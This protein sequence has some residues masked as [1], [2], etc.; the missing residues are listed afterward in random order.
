VQSASFALFT[1]NTGGWTDEV[2]FQGIPRTVENGQQVFFNNVGNGFFS[3]MGIPLVAGR[4]FNVHDTQTSPKVAVINETM[5]RRFFPNRSPIG[6]RFGIGD[7]PDHPGEIE[8]VG[9]VKDAKYTALDEGAQMAAYLPCEQ[10]TG[11]Y[12]N[13]GVRYAA[14]T[15]T[16]LLISE[17]RSAIAQANPNILVNSVSS[18]EE[19][20]S[21][22][23]AEQS[24]IARL[25]SFFGVL[26][27][28]LACIGIYGLLSYSVAR[29]TSEIGIRLALGAQGRSVL[30]MVLRESIL[31]LVLGLAVGVPATLASTRILKSLLFELSPVDT[32]TIATAIT[33]VAAMTIAAAWLPARRATKIDPMQALRTE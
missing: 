28:F 19:Q 15:N 33:A 8:V 29:R 7:V 31:L 4:V 10:N 1:F 11:F 14:G 22:S 26:A 18:L 30:W 23:V 24:L 21:L 5:A 27:V 13:F 32:L 6:Q 20:V 9:V 2:L 16:Q 17:V 12:E 3:T 25:S